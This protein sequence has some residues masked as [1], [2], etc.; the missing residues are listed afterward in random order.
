MLE[1]KSKF[2][3]GFSAKYNCN[4]LI[5]YEEFQWI[6]EAIMREKQ[7]KGGSRQKKINLV[8]STN[9]GWNDL[10][11]N[12]FTEEDINSYVPDPK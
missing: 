7:I 2:N 9:A 3:K 11:M 1:H 4:K 10:S 5:H 8:I 12:W 6:Q